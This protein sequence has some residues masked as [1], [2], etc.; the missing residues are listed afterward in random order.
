MFDF[1]KLSVYQKAVDLN[2][3][4]FTL[5]RDKRIEHALLDQLKR[6]AISIAL[7]IAEGGGRFTKAD[8]CRFYVIARGSAFEVTACL[9]LAERLRQISVLE[10]QPIQFKIEEIARMLCGLI[11]NTTTQKIQF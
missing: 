10:C 2:E 6:A 9:E 8:K 7:N 4:L 11:K 5:L 1:Q 3:I